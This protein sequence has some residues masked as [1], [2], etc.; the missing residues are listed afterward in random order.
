MRAALYARVST[1]EQVEG[2]SIEGQLA[3]TRGYALDRGWQV[4]EEYVDPG[5]SARTDNRPAFKRMIS[6]AKQ[7]KFDVVLVL[8]GDRF[9]RNRMHAAMYK[10]LLREVGVK[11]VS[12]SEPI[13]EGTPAGVILEGMNEV[14]AEWYSVD[15]SVKVAD[16]KRRRAEKGLWNG[17]VPFGYIPKEGLLEI[18][19]A[20]AELVNHTFEMYASGRY[21]DEAVATWLNQTDSRPRVHRKDRKDNGYLWSKDTVR[22]MLRNPFYLGHVKYKKELM[23]GKHPAI[24]TEEL[25]GNVQRVRRE[26]HKGPWTYTPRHRTYLLGGLVRCAD[27]GRKLWSQHLSGKDYYRE[28]A[29]LRGLPCGEGKSVMRAEHLESQVEA[30]IT[31]LRLPTSWRELVAEYFASTDEKRRLVTERERLVER[32]R[33]LYHTYLDGLPEYDYRREIEAIDAAIK[34]LG[35]PEDQEVV[36]LGDHV[37]GM[38]E[39]WTHASKE[40]K[41]DIL[42]MMLDA[43]YVDTSTKRIVALQIKP[44]F[45]PLFTAW[46]GTKNP[47]E[48]TVR[49]GAKKIVDGDPDGIRTHD[50]W[51]DRPVC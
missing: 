24:V 30:V 44:S 29:K 51:L 16:A 41:R 33:R 23:A 14:I 19:P 1:E 4:V 2:Y 39:A 13:E 5:F 8:R 9:A 42:C 21:T 32:K 25:F 22:D 49:L 6:D 40:E 45:K 15:L 48:T 3:S 26:H 12:V 34:N 50:L 31:S 7:S 36:A 20:E 47:D 27:C 28:E 10:Q 43:V 35:Y 46:L 38:L 17:P 11:V 37:E 18:I